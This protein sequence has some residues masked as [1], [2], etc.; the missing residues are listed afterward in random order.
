MW[1]DVLQ[2]DKTC[3]E[4]FITGQE[5]PEL[6]DHD[7]RMGGVSELRGTY[8]VGRRDPDIHTLVFAV[9]GQG[10]VSLPGQPVTAVQPGQ[11][12]FMPARKPFRFEIDGDDWQTCWL[13]LPDTDRWAFLTTRSAGVFSSQVCWSLFHLMQSLYHQA[14][15]PRRAR[16]VAML[17]EVLSEEVT[18]EPTR[19]AQQE[20]LMQLFNQLEDRLHAPWTLDTL[21]AEVHY[22]PSH[23]H[24]LC[25]RYFHCSPM[26]RVS[27][28]RLN[29]A[30]ELLRY[31]EWQIRQIGQRVGYHDPINFTHW[32]RRRTGQSPTD[33]RQRS[34]RDD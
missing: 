15:S 29:K 19:D 5:F 3:R 10:K 6:A 22:S 9:G 1:E 24:R 33:W 16:L 14:H 34:R 17:A 21:A 18:R 26:Q 20:R 31:T 8:V 12:I 4:H 7:F 11:F 27:T 28:M 32:F 2:L 23:L 25:H 30:C 13:L